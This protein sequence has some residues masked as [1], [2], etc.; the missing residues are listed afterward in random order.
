MKQYID[1]SVQ[2]CA[3]LFIISALVFTGSYVYVDAVNES[4]KISTCNNVNDPS[5]AQ[6]KVA[7]D[8]S[9]IRTL[10]NQPDPPIFI[11][12]IMS[13]DET[14]YNKE[15]N[16]YYVASFM[17]GA[18]MQMADTV[19]ASSMHLVIPQMLFALFW[20]ILALI[21]IFTYILL[22]TYNFM[23]GGL[24]QEVCNLIINLINGWIFQWDKGFAGF[25]W[26]I[27]LIILIVVMGSIAI[28]S[29][30]G[31]VPIMSSVKSIFQA[32][33][34]MFLIGFLSQYMVSI[35]TTIDKYASDM[36]SQITLS[37]VTESDD[38]PS[39][40]RTKSLIYELTE[41]QPFMMRYFGVMSDTQIPPKTV[42]TDHTDQETLTGPDR[43]W[44]LWNGWDYN[45]WSGDEPTTLKAARIE[46]CRNVD[47]VFP[48]NGCPGSG[49]EVENSQRL[50]TMVTRNHS[51]DAMLVLLFMTILMIPQTLMLQFFIF[52]MLLFLSVLRGIVLIRPAFAAF[53][54][55]KAF[56]QQS[57]GA[58]ADYFNSL[59]K[60]EIITLLLAGIFSVIMLLMMKTY[61][62]VSKISPMLTFGVSSMWFVVA[63]VAW[64]FK[65]R[66]FT[67]L[68]K[69]MK[70]LGGLA[71]AGMNDMHADPMDAL[72]DFG[73][74]IGESFD[75]SFGPQSRGGTGKMNSDEPVDTNDVTDSSKVKKEA[76]VDER[77]DVYVETEE[78]IALQEKTDS[79]P[80]INDDTDEGIFDADAYLYE[81]GDSN[82]SKNQ[83]NIDDVSDGMNG[84]ITM[85]DIAS[86]EPSIEVDDNVNDAFQEFNMQHADPQND[87]VDYLDQDGFVDTT[88]N[89]RGSDLNENTQETSH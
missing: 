18:N 80:T 88:E 3:L 26:K 48:S 77:D 69:A 67:F 39:E 82:A 40:I 51:F 52:I 12:A 11:K 2:F 53:E 14:T 38:T 83:G 58:I 84:D 61:I 22:F 28:R 66:I 21:L 36:T 1:K 73:K 56:F 75:E 70:A 68:Q 23:F 49:K 35:T 72:G 74:Q 6:T 32:I 34:I 15:K 43:F 30:K 20:I 5:C 37:T 7:Q 55:C 47:A 33:L 86:G 19:D 65:D 8:G 17:N 76:Y 46:A 4:P 71:V 10:N 79:K 50:L 81:E 29:I 85:S 13:R 27:L 16:Q 89:D 9:Y 59:F 41:V 42:D 25:G 45:G 64:V 87:S 78:D 44:R 60:W 54:M 57:F 31:H 24:F 62:E 63:I